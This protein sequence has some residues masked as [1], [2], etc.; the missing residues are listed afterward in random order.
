MEPPPLRRGPLILAL[1][2][3]GCTTAP[4]SPD[5]AAPAR[6][7]R[8]APKPQ[9]AAPAPTP[10]ALASAVAAPVPERPPGPFSENIVRDVVRKSFDK[11][12]ECYAEGLTRDKK[13]AGTIEVQ[14]AIDDAGDVIG[15][16]APKGPRASKKTKDGD[17]R[18]LDAT[19]IGC[20]EQHFKTLRFPPT[21]RGLVNIVYSVVF[22]VQ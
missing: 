8:P 18:I 3:A 6:S 22:K 14:L 7:A 21:G 12:G 15:A 20:V 17:T 5:D 13:L 4:A 19:V 1:V 16:T 9:V 2:V 10:S 11:L